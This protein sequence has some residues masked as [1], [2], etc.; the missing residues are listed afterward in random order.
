MLVCSTILI[1]LQAYKSCGNVL[2]CPQI[3]VRTFFSL[4]LIAENEKLQK[5]LAVLRTVDDV[6]STTGNFMESEK[7]VC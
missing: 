4:Q 1:F 3:N 5:E 2:Q 6:A 7:K